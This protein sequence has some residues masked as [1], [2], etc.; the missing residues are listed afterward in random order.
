M[1]WSADEKKP[2]VEENSKETLDAKA[3]D[4][5]YRVVI[6]WHYSKTNEPNRVYVCGSWDGWDS[7][8]RLHKNDDIFSTVLHLSPGYYEYKFCVDNEWLTNEHLPFTDVGYYSRNI[9]TVKEDE[10]EA[11]EQTRTI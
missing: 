8:L 9:I 10:N 11:V 3:E 2:L 7:R 5:K 4:V 1:D 6:T